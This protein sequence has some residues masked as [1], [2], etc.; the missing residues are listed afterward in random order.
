[1]PLACLICGEGQEKV[2]MTMKRV[3]FVISAGLT[4]AVAA[5]GSTEQGSHTVAVDR[6]QLGDTLR[7]HSLRP[8]FGDT[9]T[10]RKVAQIGVA[11]GEKRDMLN[12]VTSFVELPD[13]RVVVADD[14]GLRRFAPSG[15]FLDY[16]ARPGQGPGEV[17]YVVGMAVAPDGTLLAADL[18]NRRIN[19]YR[20]SGALEHWPLPPGMPGYG[21]H[22]ITATRDGRVYVAYNPPVPSDGSPMHYPRALFVRLDSSGTVLDTLSAA[23][24]FTVPCPTVSSLWWRAGFY[25]DVREPYFPKVKWAL[26]PSGTLAVGCPLEYKVDMIRPDGSILRIVRDW[27]PVTVPTEERR[28][29]MTIETFAQRR[30]GYFKSW[31]WQGP[32]PPEEKPA[33]DRMIFGEDGRLWVW[34]AH[35]SVK[36]DVPQEFIRQGLPRVQYTVRT[37]GAFDVFEPTGEYVG[38]VRLPE[39]VP[40][41]PFPGASDPFIRGDSVWAVRHDSLGVQYVAKYVVQWPVAASGDANGT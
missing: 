4:V 1:V 34:P 36:R 31:G 39:D 13:G 24:R 26:G 18:G 29:F 3:G 25:E 15:A 12:D 40:Y 33:Y 16:L 19:V 8:R 5:C 27:R 22:S 10:L 41:Q 21:R 20:S 38:A 14:Q 23:V 6:Q 17:R 9:A 32:E 11:E 37:A 2:V 30:S 28:A 35:P 7:V